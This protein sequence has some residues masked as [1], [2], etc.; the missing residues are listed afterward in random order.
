MLYV[1]LTIGRG[2]ALTAVVAREES[3]NVFLEGRERMIRNLRNRPTYRPQRSIRVVEVSRFPFAGDLTRLANPVSEAILRVQGQKEDDGD[4]RLVGE[5]SDYVFGRSVRDFLPQLR[6]ILWGVSYST[7]L[8]VVSAD[9]PR[10]TAEGWRVKVPRRDVVHALSKRS[11]EQT[12]ALDV[13]GPLA[14]ELAT[15]LSDLTQKPQRGADEAAPEE[16]LALGV[17][18]VCFAQENRPVAGTVNDISFPGDDAPAKPL[19][20][21]EVTGWGGRR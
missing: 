15:Q 14:K 6:G 21:S 9:I 16:D 13:K 20:P 10:A 17:A 5:C 7:A 19:R 2:P 11:A 4:I 18:L 3:R 1:A 8:E 12:L